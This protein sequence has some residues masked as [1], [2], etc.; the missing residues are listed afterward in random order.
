MHFAYKLQPILMPMKYITVITLLLSAFS[1]N[2]QHNPDAILGKWESAEKNLIVEVYKQDD[3]FQARIVWF[4]N[5]ENMLPETD[6]KNPNE[7]LRSRKIVGMDVLSGLKYNARQNRWTDGKIYDC[8]SGRTWDATVWLISPND[9]KV[10]GYYLVR[11]L[12][13]TMMFTRVK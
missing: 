13:K 9:L 3:N 2:A 6:I 1:L 4:S 8:T 7:E 5:P 11:W 10:R 12:G